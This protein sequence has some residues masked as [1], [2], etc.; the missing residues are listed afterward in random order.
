[1][2]SIAET[3]PSRGLKA[4]VVNPSRFGGLRQMKPITIPKKTPE[5][6][7]IGPTVQFIP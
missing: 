6:L 4:A 5:A 1:M 7:V 3:I 2:R